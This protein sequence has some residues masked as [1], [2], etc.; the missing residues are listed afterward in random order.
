MVDSKQMLPEIILMR[1]ICILSIIIGH[2][3]AI[4]SGAWGGSSIPYVKEYQ[5]V[6]P[7]F[8]SFQLCAF[9]FI[10]VYLFEHNILKSKELS[11]INFIRKKAERILL[12]GLCFGIIYIL[13]YERENW[14]ILS[15]LCGPGH[16]WFLPMIFWAYVLLYIYRFYIC[17]YKISYWNMLVI[18]PISL[19]VMRFGLP[20]GISN[21][22][23]YFPFML[24]GSI[25][26]N[27]KE[28]FSILERKRSLLIYGISYIL[29]II[30]FLMKIGN[31]LSLFMVKY[32]IN[33]IG[34]MFLWHICSTFKGK[35]HNT[36]HILNKSSY[37]MYLIH[38]FFLI[39][40]FYYSSVMLDLNRY[41][42]PFVSLIFTLLF[43]YIIVSFLKRTRMGVYI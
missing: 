40:F 34:V 24:L 19:L 13:L 18:I 22:F 43:S 37:G 6:N 16:L 3:F 41:V 17:R 5:Y 26:Y 14:N 9:V 39:Y 7:I 38:Q 28:Y 27:K 25:V 1:P 2:A 21:A 30:L 15:L 12:P 29:L 8:I 31:S 4:Y 11:F 10:S 32:A 36:W 23:F 35:L 33:F 20:F 42:I